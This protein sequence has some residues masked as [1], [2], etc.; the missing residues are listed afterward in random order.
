MRK[1]LLSLAAVGIGL[2][3]AGWILTAPETLEAGFAAGHKAD[4]QNGSLVFAAAGCSSCHTA[5]DS[6]DNAEDAP[7]VLAGGQAF[8]SDFG[9]FYAPNISSDP[10]AGIGG[11]TLPQFARAVTAGVSPEGRHYYPAFPYAAYQHMTES[12]VADLFAYLQTL[13]AAEAEAPAHAVPF[14]FNI[15]R[16]LGAWKLAFMPDEYAVGGGLT[17]EQERGR[18]LAEGLAHCGECHTPRNAAGGLLP[19]RWL[20]GA[21]NPDGKGQIPNITPAELTWS[22][23]DL[24]EYFTS[25]FTPDYD[26]AGGQ[27]AHVVANL[28]KLPQADREAIAAYLQ[29]VPPVADETPAE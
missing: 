11:W 13:P 26:T 22:Q 29:A 7:P 3:A 17:P 25:G 16:G 6:P 10:T 15:R 20:A 9:T 8:D 21:P 5:P 27:M 1:T 2:G 12:D 14:P 4:A 19:K 24:V 23:A 28:A 18:Y